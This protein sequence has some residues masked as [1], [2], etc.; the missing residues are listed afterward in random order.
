[1]ATFTKIGT[2]VAGG[3]FVAIEADCQAMA[4]LFPEH[5]VV[6]RWFLHMTGGARRI[7]MAERT[8]ILLLKAIFGLREF[9]VFALPSNAVAVMHIRGFFPRTSI[10]V[11]FTAIGVGI[12]VFMFVFPFRNEIF[13]GVTPGDRTL[14]ILIGH[15]KSDR[16]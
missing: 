2:V 7:G 6:L 14:T 13:I 5:G 10:I 11:A 16:D 8:D 15:Q 9:T 1:M 3:A 4:A 12:N